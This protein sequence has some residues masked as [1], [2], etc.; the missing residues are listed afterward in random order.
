M[1]EAVFISPRANDLAKD[2]AH[3]VHDDIVSIL[4][5]VPLLLYDASNTDGQPFSAVQKDPAGRPAGPLTHTHG[6]IG[7]RARATHR[8]N[9][10]TNHP[11][12]MSAVGGKRV[13]PDPP[14]RAL[15]VLNLKQRS[16]IEMEMTADLML[17]L[18]GTVSLATFCAALCLG[19]EMGK[20]D[21]AIRLANGFHV[22]FE[23][24]GG[25][26]HTEDPERVQGD[27]EKTIRMLVG[28]ANALVVRVRADGAPDIT[29]EIHTAIEESDSL[30]DEDKDRVVLVHLKRD[31]PSNRSFEA[32]K[33]IVGAVQPL[34][35]DQ[36]GE[37]QRPFAD[38]LQKAKKVLKNRDAIDLVQ[39][40]LRT[41][42]RAYDENVKKL[43]KALGGNESATQRVL[44]ADG[45]ITS[46]TC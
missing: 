30:N 41:F 6:A 16:K 34:L 14:P 1:I 40:T 46:R 36:G 8:R 2:W 5:N 7:A 11:K 43:K 27:V 28:C 21:S 39:D 35:V 31:A 12:P 4:P 42:V 33:A 29:E 3:A 37:K 44:D 13:M 17:A 26:W 45:V 15:Q 9:R 32:L 25:C 10:P 20:A 22:L 23:W 38:R 19:D 18:L 24:D